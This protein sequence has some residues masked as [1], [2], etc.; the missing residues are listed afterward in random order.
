MCLCNPSAPI[1]PWLSRNA[2][3]KS[4]VWA[5]WRAQ[6]ATLSQDLLTYKQDPAVGRG[7]VWR[8]PGKEVRYEM[9]LVHA[10]SKPQQ[11]LSD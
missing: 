4:G 11:W 1:E 3:W 10:E 7:K 2:Y 5:E 6:E 8:E 9:L